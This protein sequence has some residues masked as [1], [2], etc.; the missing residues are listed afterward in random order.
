MIALTRRRQASR[1]QPAAAPV[2]VEA[3]RRHFAFPGAG[4]VVTNNAASTQPPRELLAL[5]RSLAP[6][7]ENVHRWSHSTSPAATRPASPRR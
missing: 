2:D 7:Y 1:Q 4:R 6:E 3:I 5:Y